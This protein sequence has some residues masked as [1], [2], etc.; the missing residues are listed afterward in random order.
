VFRLRR[1][2]SH[3]AAAAAIGGNVETARRILLSRCVSPADESDTSV[4]G[5]PESSQTAIA[6]DLATIDPQ[7][8]ILLDL[9]CPACGNTWLAVF[10]VASFLWT[11]IRSR[12]RRFVQEVDVLARTYGWAEADILNM[13][14]TRRGVYLQ[15]AMS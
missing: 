15:M 10:D 12:A 5:L 3:D 6:A 1:P 9:G 7:A 11:E 13:S 2:T 14:D 4:D 8:E